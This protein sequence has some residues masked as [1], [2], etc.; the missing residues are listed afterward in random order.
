MNTDFWKK[1]LAKDKAVWTQLLEQSANSE[2]LVL[3]CTSVGSHGPVVIH[4]SVLS[5]ALIAR[6]FRVEVLLCDGVLPACEA[7][8]Y[9]GSKPEVFLQ[10]GPQARYCKPCWSQGLEVF[11]GLGIPIH[12]Y[13]DFL[14][15]DDYVY[16][17]EVVKNLEGNELRL[18]TLD[19]IH[20]GEEAYAGSLRF[21]AT[22]DLS[23]EPDKIAILRR[24]LQGA[25]LTQKAIQRV[26]S[27]L[28][29]NVAVFHHGIYVPQG[30]I[31]QVARQLGIRVVNWSVGYRKQ[32][33]VYSH[34]DTYHR[35]MIDESVDI[36]RNRKISELERSHLYEYLNSRKNSSQ[37]WVKFNQEPEENITLIRERLELDS[38]PII[39]LLTNVTW[40]AQLYY[41]NNGFPSLLDWLYYTILYFNKREDL[42]LIIRVHPSEVRGTMPTRQ[43]VMA[44]IAK[45]LSALP[46]NVRIV[47]AADDIST[48]TLA[49]MSDCVIIYGTKTGVEL[50]ARGIPVIVVGEAWIRNKGLTIDVSTEEEY[51]HC[52]EKL[53]LNQ[54]MSDEQVELA[55]QY[56]YHYFFRR[57]IPIKSL[58]YQQEQSSLPR[59]SHL[60]KFFQQQL[61]RKLKPENSAGDINSPFSVSLSEIR[62]IEAG[63]DKGLDTV[64]NGIAHGSEFIFD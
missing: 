17:Q 55:L 16:A 45:K 18:Y 59:E 20:L 39:L 44:E 4:D 63:H 54:R 60:S 8:T 34:S 46:Q 24:Y 9:Y 42:Q 48:Y 22:G 57:L 50:T 10:E 38:R 58:V 23:S 11:S 52:L 13:G 40:D 53:P 36:W 49:D 51:L 6:G 64:C 43:P 3:F 62:E 27:Q 25:I 5:A 12:Q 37:D 21:F 41:K 47:D 15:E 31:G 33:F 61:V 35:T 32:T 29:P 2:E 1:T 28:N 26:F 30:V 7:C 14:S 19:G 56:A